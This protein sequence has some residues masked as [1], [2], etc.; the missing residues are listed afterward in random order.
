MSLCKL[1]PSIEDS[2]FSLHF[3]S[4]TFC[5]KIVC[6][7]PLMSS[8]WNCAYIF[9]RLWQQ[10]SSS[11]QT[12]WTPVL[13]ET[14][15]PPASPRA[16]LGFQYAFDS[17]ITCSFCHSFT[18]LCQGPFCHHLSSLH[19]LVAASKCRV[20]AWYG[21]VDCCILWLLNVL[22]SWAAWSG[23]LMGANHTAGGSREA[24]GKRKTD[25]SLHCITKH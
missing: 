22:G 24:T 8:M 17:W 19:A 25:R 11:S 15:A 9:L 16:S 3:V 10:G 5:M 12:V 13:G 2:A 20:L 1:S 23:S 14:Q 21:I 18:R 6:H 7:I 4:V